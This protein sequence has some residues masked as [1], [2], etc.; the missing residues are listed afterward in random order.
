MRLSPRSYRRW[1][2]GSGGCRTAER[3]AAGVIRQREQAFRAMNENTRNMLL[4]AAVSMI[5]IG[6]WD[7][8]YAFPEMDRQKKVIA[9]Q[10]RLAKITPLGAPEKTSGGQALATTRTARSDHLAATDSGHA[11]A[12]TMTALA[13]DLA[14]LIGPFH[15]R[16]PQAAEPPIL[17]KTNPN[18]PFSTRGSDPRSPAENRRARTAKRDGVA[19]VGE[20]RR[21][22]I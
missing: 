3:R 19:P 8:F 22:R 4:A 6:L 5:F 13:H 17:L 11:G 12:K 16:S 21:G 18:R 14:G 10:E 7:Y 1:P 20:Q 9:E 15:R 2:R